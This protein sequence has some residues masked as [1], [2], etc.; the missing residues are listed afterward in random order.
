MVP[1][2]KNNNFEDLLKS[3]NQITVHQRNLQV[4]ITELLK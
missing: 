1:N 3:N 2:D 4:L